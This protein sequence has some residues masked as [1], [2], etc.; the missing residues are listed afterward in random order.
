MKERIAVQIKIHTHIHHVLDEEISVSY[1][2]VKFNAPSFD[3]D[4][5][6]VG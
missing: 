6:S 2:S 5:I 3:M 4:L 1:R